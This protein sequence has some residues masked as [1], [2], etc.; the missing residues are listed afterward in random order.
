MM[1]GTLKG[2]MNVKHIFNRK[3]EK[4]NKKTIDGKNLKKIR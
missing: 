2:S 3:P 4:K 1:Q